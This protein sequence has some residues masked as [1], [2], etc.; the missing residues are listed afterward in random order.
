[1]KQK[2]HLLK[3]FE[4]QPI[5]LLILIIHWKSTPELPTTDKI[6][7]ECKYIPESPNFNA[8]ILCKTRV[9]PGFC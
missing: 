6:L 1:M 8:I 2:I 9:K 5:S 7:A 4:Q 3:R